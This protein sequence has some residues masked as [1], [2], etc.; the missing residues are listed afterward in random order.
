MQ[1]TLQHVVQSQRFIWH[2][3]I[4]E[5]LR[6]IFA[7]N[8][9]SIIV[10]ISIN[11]KFTKYKEKIK[12]SIKLGKCILFKTNDWVLGL[13]STTLHSASISVTLNKLFIAFELSK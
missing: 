12:S 5:Y 3:G 6:L 1:L 10:K 13:Y 7:E 11:N 9:A 4:I 8:G 2:H